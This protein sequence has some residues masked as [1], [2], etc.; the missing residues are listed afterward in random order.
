M[1]KLGLANEIV[2]WVWL[3]KMSRLLVLMRL[4]VFF[5]EFWL[6]LVLMM[7]DGSLSDVWLRILVVSLVLVFRILALVEWVKLIWFGM[8]LVTRIWLMVFCSV[9]IVASLIGSASS[10]SV[11]LF[12][13][14]CVRCIVC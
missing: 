8:M 12:G 13:C 5:I 11:M 7:I 9:C 1:W 14:G 2:L 3:M 10:I 6:S 4:N